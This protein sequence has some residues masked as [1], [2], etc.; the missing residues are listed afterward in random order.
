MA[1]SR[2]P[3]PES[4]PLVSD[5]LQELDELDEPELEDELDDEDEPCR[6]LSP[7]RSSF[8][9][10]AGC[11][12]QT[13]DRIRRKARTN[14]QRIRVTPR[15]QQSACQAATS[16]SSAKFPRNHAARTKADCDR[17]FTQGVATRARRADSSLGGTTSPMTDGAEASWVHELR[18]S[19]ISVTCK[20]RGAGD[21]LTL[22]SWAD[23]LRR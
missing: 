19:S 12:L 2:A 22:A 21:S 14:W 15:L 3:S 4:S 23:L 17:P 20:R 16:P 13:R 9:A 11:E 10:R 5:E 8:P 1:A 18:G 6:A 7:A